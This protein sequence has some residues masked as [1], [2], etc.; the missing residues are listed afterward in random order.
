MDNLPDSLYTDY[1]DGSSSSSNAAPPNN[2]GSATSAL[3]ATERSKIGWLI[4]LVNSPHTRSEAIMQLNNIFQKN[5]LT[6]GINHPILERSVA[7]KADVA[8]PALFGG[9]AL[10]LDEEPSA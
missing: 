1:A 8:D 6:N 3:S 9:A 2:A 10:E 5:K 7:D 4:P